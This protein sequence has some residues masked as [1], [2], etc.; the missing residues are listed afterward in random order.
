MLG[1]VREQMSP[2]GSRWVPGVGGGQ[3]IGREFPRVLLLG[4]IK[5]GVPTAPRGR[6]SAVLSVFD[7]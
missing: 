6:G 7:R 2:R 3:G 1:G 5:R 4:I